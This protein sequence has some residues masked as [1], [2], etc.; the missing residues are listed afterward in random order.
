MNATYIDELTTE[1]PKSI[2]SAAVREFE[3]K[4]LNNSST[5]PSLRY[6]IPRTQEELNSARKAAVPKKTADDMQWCL[7]VWKGWSE[8]RNAVCPTEKIPITEKEL[9]KA[10]EDLLCFSLPRFMLKIRNQY[11]GECAPDTLHHLV[12]G[13]LRHVSY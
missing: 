3:K 10:D 12:C 1:L 7:K 4:Y 8:H 13:V 11:G 5:T 9:P 6:T 2:P